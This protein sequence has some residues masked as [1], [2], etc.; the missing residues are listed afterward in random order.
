[1]TPSINFKLQHQALWPGS[2]L[3]NFHRLVLIVP[4]P[5]WHPRDFNHFS[6][7]LGPIQVSFPSIRGFS[8]ELSLHIRWPKYWSFSFSISPSNEYSG[9]IFFR[10][11]WF[12]LPGV[13]GLSRIF[14]STTIQKHQFFSAQPALWSNFHIHTWLLEKLHLWLY[15]PS[16]A[17]WCLC[18]LI[19]CL[20]LS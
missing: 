14:S 4:H 18:F 6:G 16:L 8:N 12:D 9:L 1:M 15:G 11:D 7:L 17:K 13:Q 2:Q 10:I 19:C 20:G 5:Y 3:S